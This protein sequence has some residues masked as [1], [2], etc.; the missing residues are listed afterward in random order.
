[1]SQEDWDNPETRCFGL[2][3]AGDAIDEVDS[4]G[5]P[6]VGDTLLILLNSHHEPISFVL[7]DPEKAL[8]QLFLDTREETGRPDYL[9]IRG[10]EPYRLEARSLALFRFRA[11]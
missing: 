4:R 2:R 10:G 11:G 1:M 9:E 7:P 3:L 6:I 5:N 8:W